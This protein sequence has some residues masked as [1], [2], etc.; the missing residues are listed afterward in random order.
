MA[1]K[2]V[3]DYYN[4]ETRNYM[5][6]YC[7]HISC[8]KYN[9]IKHL[10]SEKHKNI[11]S[12]KSREKVGKKYNC[13]LCDHISRDKY[14]YIKHLNTKK[15]KSMSINQHNSTK[16]NNKNNNKEIVYKCQ[17]GKSYKHI[18]SLYRHNKKCKIDIHTVES[19]NVNMLELKNEIQELKNE[20]LNMS[21]NIP[22]QTLS[23]NTI[24][25]SFNNKNEIKIFLTEKCANAISIE[26]FV[27]QLT[28]TMEDLHN[29][30]DN[31]V[32]A[33]TGIIERNL[34]PLTIT[35]RPIHHI[36]NDE[37]F[38]KDKEEWT[39][40]DG[41][42]FINKACNKIQNDCVKEV[43]KSTLSC[44]DYIEMLHSSTKELSS[45]EKTRIKEKIKDN[46]KIVNS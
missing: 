31:N 15:H 7:D 12:S 22:I 25:N 4:N 37:W 35:N 46:C 3:T 41:N 5:C 40:D 28:I 34:K 16:N 2:K 44:D 39:E 21:K 6:K 1:Y 17:C 10:N 32:M 24:S 43:S 38:M 19:Y 45:V 8:H 18:Q 23:N 14:N 33:I 13:D 27:K 36:E 30:R 9:F 20:I 42:I 11:E 26:D 29:T